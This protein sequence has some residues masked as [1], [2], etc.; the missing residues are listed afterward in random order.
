MGAG[1]TDDGPEFASVRRMVSALGLENT[2]QPRGLVSD[3]GNWYRRY[4]VRLGR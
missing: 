3:V 1:F 2:V 4:I